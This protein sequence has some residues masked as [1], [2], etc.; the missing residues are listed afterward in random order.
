MEFLWISTSNKRLLL[1][2]S[3]SMICLLSAKTEDRFLWLRVFPQFSKDIEGAHWQ[4][5]VPKIIIGLPIIVATVVQTHCY[6][7]LKIVPSVETLDAM[8]RHVYF[9]VANRM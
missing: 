4:L 7:S 2:V 6:C 8:D 5:W 1:L 9:G 3:I